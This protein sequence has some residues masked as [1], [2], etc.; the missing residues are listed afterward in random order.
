MEVRQGQAAGAVDLQRTLDA[1]AVCGCQAGGGHRIHLRQFG[2]HRR[3]AFLL[4]LG[5]DGGAQDGLRRW[6]GVYAVEQ[7]FDIQHGP[8]HQQRQA[9]APGD[10]ADQGLRVLH[11]FGGA[12]GLQRIADV[13]QVVRH[14]GQFGGARFGG[15][16]VHAT[17]DQRR[18]HADD[19]HRVRPGDGQ[20]GGGLATGGRT[21]QA[22]VQRQRRSGARC[23]HQRP[24]MNSRSSSATLIC[25][26]VGRPWLH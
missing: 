12:V 8:A 25:R 18:V 22:D 23:G 7:G 1:L 11:K 13:D 9:I 16:N 15:A 14:R 4:R 21:G 10:L 3:P 26:Q 6:H 20:R 19:F 5:F 24:R 2:V 17:V